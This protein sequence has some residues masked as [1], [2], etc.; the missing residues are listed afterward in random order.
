VKRDF[1][2]VVPDTVPYA[3]LA[4]ATSGLKLE[5]VRGFRPVD[6]FRGGAIPA[7]HYSLLLRVTFQSQTHTLTSEEVGGLSQR[8]LAVLEPL[9]VRLRG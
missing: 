5:E 6:Y 9:G 8:L 4:A 7:R 2:L 1:S 3:R